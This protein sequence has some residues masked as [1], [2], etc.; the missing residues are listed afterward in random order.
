MHE[1]YCGTIYGIWQ[2]RFW[3]CGLLSGRLRV[4]YPY[5]STNGLQKPAS[6][7]ATSK[8]CGLNRRSTRKVA[9]YLGVRTSLMFN[10]NA[11][12]SP[13]SNTRLRRPTKLLP[14]RPL[15]LVVLYLPSR[16]PPCSASPLAVLRRALPC[17][18]CSA[19]L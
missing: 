7:P 16:A 3:A 14:P 2:T 15:A 10:T 6:D 8:S 4:H 12:L 13:L 18:S 19:V 11:I 1:H 17:L 9:C 5:H